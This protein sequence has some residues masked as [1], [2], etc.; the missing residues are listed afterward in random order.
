MRVLIVM[1]FAA[2][3]AM[4]AQAQKIEVKETRDEFN[5]SRCDAMVVNIVEAALSD[6]EKAWRKQ[7]KDYNGKISNQKKVIF[8][9]DASIKNISDNTIDIYT[10]FSQASNGVDM[11]VA[12]D[13][14]GAWLAKS[15]H[16]QQ[17][18]AAE[19]IL[20]NFALEQSKAAVGNNVSEAQK[21]LQKREKN[22]ESLKKEN[23]GLKKDIE[24]YKES[25]EKAEKSIKENEKKQ[26]EAETAIQ[27]QQKVTKELED[28]QKSIK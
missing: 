22:L 4:Q 14:G 15:T 24:R 17:Y 16:V 6:V 26:K 10:K 25:I 12:F 28:R 18:K 3:I 27:E 19:K 5:S 9:D 13:L 7:L 23:E 8:A 20:Y 11:V 2:F 21:E 1:F